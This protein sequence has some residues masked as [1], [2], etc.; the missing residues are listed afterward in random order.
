M[1]SHFTSIVSLLSTFS[2]KSISKY[3]TDPLIISYQL[4]VNNLI[5]RD[6]NISIIDNTDGAICTT[7]PL[8]IL[9]IDNKCNNNIDNI[10]LKELCCSSRYARVHGRF[11]IPILPINNRYLCRSSTISIGAETLLNVGSSVFMSY[12]WQSNNNISNSNNNNI[13]NT[14]VKSSPALISTTSEERSQIWPQTIRQSDVELLNYLNVKYIFDLMVEGSKKVYGISVSSSEKVDLTGAYDTFKLNA[15]PYPGCEFFKYYFN[16][17]TPNEMFYDWSLPFVN[18]S[19]KLSCDDDP[20]LTLSTSELVTVDWSEWKHWS[21]ETLTCNYL[22]VLLRLLV[23]PNSDDRSGVLIHCIS[24]WDR[25]PLFASLIR[26]SL[27]ADGLAHQSLNPED[28]LYL[29]LA[30]DWFLFG[31]QFHDRRTKRE[32][33]LYFCFDFLPRISDAVFSMKNSTSDIISPDL[34]PAPTPEPDRERESSVK[35]ESSV[36]ES[37]AVPSISRVPSHESFICVDRS[38]FVTPALTG[39]SSGVDSDMS[40]LNLSPQHSA[41]QNNH[42]S[43]IRSL[44]SNTSRNGSIAFIDHSMFKN[45]ES[46]T[47]DGSVSITEPSLFKIHDKQI[48]YPSNICLKRVYLTREEKLHRVSELF[49]ESYNK[50]FPNDSFNS[51]ISDDE[52]INSK[53][54]ET[55]ND[56]YGISNIVSW[57]SNMIPVYK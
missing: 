54:N 31:H 26:L 42:N 1:E 2:I 18:S 19:V 5:L 39:I 24:G 3:R 14:L 41:R 10:K 37:S 45:E 48:E 13:N 52:I 44:K 20:E 50:V 4:H 6:Y 15:I 28:I 36:R 11:V 29:T 9:I 43:T 47:R 40:P 32:D 25:T 46:F 33:I 7:Y 49:K 30:Y 12:L 16:S 22:L 21:L 56:G 51:P 35:R 55:S 53:M 34:K 27:W 23:K 8:H 38:P 17:K 57:A